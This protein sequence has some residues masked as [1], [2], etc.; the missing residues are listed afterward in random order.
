MTETR[1]PDDPKHRVVADLNALAEPYDTLRFVQVSAR[2]LVE[3]AALPRRAQVLDIATGT[4]WA[5]MAAAQPIGP[6]GT[7]LGGGLG[8]DLLECA[9]QMVAAA[10]PTHVGCQAG[11]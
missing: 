11:Y 5:A 3:L 7:V 8:P 6:T 2:R 1:V 10:R 4:G 9:R